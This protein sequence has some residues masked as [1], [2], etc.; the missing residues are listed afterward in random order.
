MTPFSKPLR[1]L[2]VLSVCITISSCSLFRKK[3]RCNDC[4]K[5]SKIEYHENGIVQYKVRI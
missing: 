3:N 1:I 2:I 4:P 5:W